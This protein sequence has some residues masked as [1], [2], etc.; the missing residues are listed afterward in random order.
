MWFYCKKHKVEY[1]QIVC[2]RV[3]GHLGCKDCFKEDLSIKV[4]EGRFKNK[5]S[6][7]SKFPIISTFFD[8]DKNP[9]E[10]NPSNISYGS[11]LKIWLRCK[12]NHSIFTKVADQ[13]NDG[14][15]KLVCG[16]C[17]FK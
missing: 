2:D 3:N 13:T 6:L 4:R 8:Y 9:K 12:N 1:K 17:H 7:E 16:K 14:K 15:D 5:N 11:G 10:I